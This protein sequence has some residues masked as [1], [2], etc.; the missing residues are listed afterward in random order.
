MQA[1][2]CAFKRRQGKKGTSQ[3][4]DPLLELD[5]LFRVLL[6]EPLVALVDL[7]LRSRHLFQLAL[8]VAEAREQ[9]QGVTEFDY[10]VVNDVL[11][12]L[13]RPRPAP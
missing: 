13:T 3:H 1:R 6:Q 10:I 8:R 7:A 11:A 2:A 12:R 5:D 9:L 4:L